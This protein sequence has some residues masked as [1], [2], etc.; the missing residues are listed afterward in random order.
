MDT[1]IV[2]PYTDIKVS[3]FFKQGKI[4]LRSYLDKQS[5]MKHDGRKALRGDFPLGPGPPPPFGYPVGRRI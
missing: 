1:K 2:N 4:V 3:I 5:S